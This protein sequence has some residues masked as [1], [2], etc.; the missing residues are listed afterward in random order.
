MNTYLRKKAKNDF[1]KDIFKLMNNVVFGKT[2]ENFR[3][4]R[5]I[6]LVTTEK[7]INYLL[8]Q[9]NYH[10]TRFFT[11]NLLATEMKKNGDIYE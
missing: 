2:V 10:R 11:E 7:R 4:H 1:V 8:S 6:K 9:A 3:K 5:D